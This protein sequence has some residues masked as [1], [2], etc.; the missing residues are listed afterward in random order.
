MVQVGS[1]GSSTVSFTS[2]PATYTHLQIRAIAQTNRGT[3]GRD[4]LGLQINSDTGANYSWHALNG[5]GTSA[6]AGGFGSVNELRAGSAGTTTAGS[7][8]FGATII[9][10]L[11]YKNTSKYKT[12]RNLGGNDVNGTVGGAGG[13]VI[14]LSGNWSNTNAITS[15]TFYPISGS[16]FSQYS[17]FALY[18]IKGA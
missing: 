7:Q 9:D 12:V 15:L 18:G 2:I 5:D 4:L 8:F 14:L 10:I 17:S 3:Y 13:E 16:T 6:G 1:G 11:D